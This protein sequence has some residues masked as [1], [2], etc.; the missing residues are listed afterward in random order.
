MDTTI[1]DEIQEQIAEY[2]EDVKKE[3]RNINIFDLLMMRQLQA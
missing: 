1:L 2:T 3:E